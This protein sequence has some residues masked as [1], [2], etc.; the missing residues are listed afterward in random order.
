VPASEELKKMAKMLPVWKED[1][2]ALEDLSE[3]DM[4]PVMLEFLRVYECSLR[5]REM[6]L[7]IYILRDEDG[8][9]SLLFGD[10]VDR[11]E[12]QDQQIHRELIIAR[13]TLERILGLMGGY[14]RLRPLALDIECIKRASLDLRNVLG[15]AADASSCMPKSWDTHGS[16]RDLPE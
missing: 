4:A 14:D 3:A 11:K 15:L 16:L 13:A 10:Y 5:E 8:S 1:D 12:E 9:G 2:K 7:S 6:Y